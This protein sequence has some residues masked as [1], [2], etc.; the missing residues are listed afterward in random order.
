MVLGRLYA[1]IRPFHIRELSKQGFWY[2]RGFL[3]PIPCRHPG[4]TVYTETWEEVKLAAKWS[5]TLETRVT[6]SEQI[7]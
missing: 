5:K 7:L 2:L 1:N 3:E 6:N 4:L